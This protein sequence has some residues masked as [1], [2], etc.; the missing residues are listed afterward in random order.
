MSSVMYFRAQ[1]HNNAW[2]NYRLLGACSKLTA[3]ELAAERTSF[4]PTIIHTLNHILTVDWFYVSSLEGAS[5]GYAAFDPEIPCPEFGDLA[6]EQRLVDQRLIALCDALTDAELTGAINLLRGKRI[7]TERKDRTLLHLFG[8][9]I[10]HRGQV[11]AML[12]GTAVAPPQLDEFFLDD[13]QERA[14][15]RDDFAALGFDE[16]AIWQA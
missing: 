3:A 6:R 13:E 4:F 9:Q 14:L 12:S 16:A 10:H 2:A 5:I 1:A 8:H 7:Q 15:R 11:H